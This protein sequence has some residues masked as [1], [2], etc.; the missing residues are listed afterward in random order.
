MVANYA[1]KCGVIRKLN[2]I[3]QLIMT[4]LKVGR[5]MLRRTTTTTNTTTK[6]TRTVFVL[7]AA[8]AAVLFGG[9]ITALAVLAPEQLAEATAAASDV[10]CSGCVGTSDI[11]SSAVTSAKIGSGQ[12]ANSDI[13]NDA[14]GSA[15][16][17]AG[18]VANSD[19]ASSAVTTG[20]ISDGTITSADIGNVISIVQGDPIALGTEGFTTT[21]S[22]T[23][24]TGKILT[25][26]GFFATGVAAG[27]ARVTSNHPADANT[28]TVSGFNAGTNDDVRLHPYA[29]CI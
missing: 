6:P 12:V 1:E 27:N 11:A 13:A 4:F 21:G 8:A 28:W 2:K 26:G 15:K 19:I 22:A 29:L 20:K 9:Y 5:E 16:I 17:A 3:C 14:V 18:Q 23:C 24:P 7:V 25:G 10:V